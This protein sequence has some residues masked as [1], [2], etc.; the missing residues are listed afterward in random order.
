MLREVSL[1][2]ERV[3]IGRKAHNDVQIDNLAIS[4]EH[5]VILRQQQGYCIEDLG[6]TNGTQVNGQAVKRQRLQHGDVIALGRYRLSYVEEAASRVPSP[7]VSALAVLQVLSG[8][9][10]GKQLVLNKELS[11]LGKPGT[12]VAAIR[13]QA[14]GYFLSHVEGEDFPRLNGKV[15]DAQAHLLA[16]HDVIELAGVKMR[17]FYPS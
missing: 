8:A 12:Q 1:D 6:S 2:R 14:Q 16:E 3:S 5:A 4:A 15:L 17:F 13:R 10:A 7:A 11:T 9:Q